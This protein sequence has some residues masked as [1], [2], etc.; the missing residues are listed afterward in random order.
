MCTKEELPVCPVATTVSLI[1]S[2]WKRGSHR[3]ICRHM[4]FPAGDAAD[5]ENHAPCAF[6][7]T[8]GIVVKS[9]R[10]VFGWVTLR[11]AADRACAGTA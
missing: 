4:V 7:G 8:R 5:Q 3:L 6:C 11:A 1:G 2:K 9:K 10:I